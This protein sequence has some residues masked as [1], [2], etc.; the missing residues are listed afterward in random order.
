M[1]IDATFGTGVVNVWKQAIGQPTQPTLKSGKMRIV[2]GWLLITSST[3]SS[4]SNGIGGLPYCWDYR[5]NPS[6]LFVAA[7]TWRCFSGK[8]FTAQQDAADRATRRPTWNFGGPLSKRWTRTI[9]LR[10]QRAL[11]R[12]R[13]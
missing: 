13:K 10:E 9:N 1:A 7:Q 4:N 11:L 5:P 12:L 8:C 3:K 2:V 6:A